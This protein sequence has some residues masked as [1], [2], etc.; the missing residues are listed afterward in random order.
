[1]GIKA[2]AERRRDHRKEFFA[3]FALLESARLLRRA[4]LQGVRMRTKLVSIVPAFVIVLGLAGCGRTGGEGVQ[5][6]KPA[7]EFQLSDLGGHQVSL[8]QFR[9]KVVILDFWATWCGPCRLSMPVLEK[10]Q[11]RY[12]NRLVLLAINLQDEPDDVREYVQ[13]RRITSTVLLDA[14]GTVGRIYESN[15]IPMQVLIDRDGV[16]RNIQVGYNS[17]LGDRLKEQIDKLL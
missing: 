14:D 1:M 15:S 2:A 12:G 3:I 4:Y 6:G 10:L 7:P 16:V 11:Q 17:R 9:G 13:S 5:V 8:S